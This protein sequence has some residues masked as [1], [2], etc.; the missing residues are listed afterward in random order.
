MKL[1]AC[2]PVYKERQLLLIAR[3]LRDDSPDT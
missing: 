1:L 2:H 3:R